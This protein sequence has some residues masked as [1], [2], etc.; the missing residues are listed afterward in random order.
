[1]VDVSHVAKGAM[2]Q[3]TEL[4]STPV[5]ATHSS[6]RAL[7]D[8]PRNLDDEQL[9]RLG[10]TGGLVQITLV[11]FFLKR[12]QKE[13][14]VTLSDYVDHIDYAVQRIGVAHV[15]IGTDFDG[16]GGVVGFH[17][18]GESANLTAE[19]MRRGYDTQAIAA[20][21]GGNFLRLLRIAEEKAG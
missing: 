12:G 4:S 11:S 7:C 20:L 3:A 1:M 6:V 5:V 17:D 2:M 18:A 21:W 14:E 19:L 13:S 10:E 15:G 16:G 9:D 8:H